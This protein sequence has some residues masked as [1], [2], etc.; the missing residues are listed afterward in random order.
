MA[1]LTWGAATAVMVTVRA[2]GQRGLG[3]TYST[4]AAAGIV[5]DHLASA[6]T[7]RDPMDVT[8]CWEAM[9]RA[10][11]N[12]GTRGLVMQAISAVDIALWD[13]TTCSLPLYWGRS[14][15][16]SRST[17]PAVSPP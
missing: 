10:S 2:G 1:T 14:A 17:D 6:I 9:P 4:P 15:I 12:L 13:L 7:A 8:G 11:R 5:A 3:W 16:P